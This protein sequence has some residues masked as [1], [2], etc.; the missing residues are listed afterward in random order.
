MKAQSLYSYFPSKHAIYDA[1]FRQGYEAFLV[2]AVADAP[3]PSLAAQLP[4]VARAEAI[5]REALTGAL[6]FFD[7]CIAHPVRYQ[8]LFQRVLPDFQPSAASMAVAME[9]YQATVGQLA[10]IGVTDQAGLDLWTAMVTGLV[11]QQ[12]SN[13]PGGTRWRDLVPRA[14]RMMLAEHQRLDHETDQ[15]GR[16][17]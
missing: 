4:A 14:V 5:E 3:R 1:M 2:E 13:D 11:D 6:A 9:A 8:L 12:L 15:H 10:E 17:R 16:K 7:F